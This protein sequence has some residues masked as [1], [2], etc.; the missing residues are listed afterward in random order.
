MR[1]HVLFAEHITRIIRV[2]HPYIRL[3]LAYADSDMF[4][5]GSSS[6]VRTA[7]ETSICELMERQL[8]T[9]FDRDRLVFGRQ[10]ELIPKA[11]NARDFALMS[12]YERQLLR[13]DY[14]E[15]G[16]D[17]PIHWA[18]C[19]GIGEDGSLSSRLMPASL[20]YLR[21]SR[22]FPSE[23]FTATLSAGIA[24]GTSYCDA[25]LHA[26]YELVERDAFAIMWLNRLS[27]PKVDVGLLESAFL[28]DSMKRLLA[29]GFRL[30][31]LDLTTEI[32]IPVYLAIIQQSDGRM[33][34]VDWMALGLGANLNP[35][36][37]VQRAY[38]EALE[39]LV[40]FC[41]FDDCGEIMPRRL[42]IEGADIDLEAYYR[43][44]RFLTRSDILVPL[45]DATR[46]DVN[47]SERTSEL[48]ACLQ[49]L[50]KCGI[51]CYFSDLTPGELRNVSYRLV[52]AFGSHLQPH[53]YDW[54]C[55]R[56]DNPRLFSSPVSSGMRHCPSEE[57]ELNLLPNPYA[58]MDR[59]GFG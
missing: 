14:V 56:L 59:L 48:E 10:S 46:Y 52:R 50:Q 8:A 32:S 6:D 23:R 44:C 35:M 57:R 2:Q 40:N 18:P 37:A 5:E 20:T 28:Q 39:V 19:V 22:Q 27:A 36:K 45:R 43:S 11:V 4:G 25:L 1:F 9:R 33:G 21:F 7:L 54:N 12:A 41:R 38:S 42:T 53:S 26:F 55:W 49:F 24:A 51:Q 47:T 31:F 30:T 16:E 29:D 58:I 15:F 3:F 17:L 13:N 34:T